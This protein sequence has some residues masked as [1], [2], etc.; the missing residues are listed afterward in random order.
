MQDD[1]E[2]VNVDEEAP[3]MENNP[4]KVDEEHEKKETENPDDDDFQCS[5]CGLCYSNKANLK[6]HM[7]RKHNN[8]KRK[9]SGKRRNSSG[10]PVKTDFQ[11]RHCGKYLSNKYNLK[12]HI[13]DNHKDEEEGINHVQIDDLNGDFQILNAKSVFECSDCDKTFENEKVL[14]I[15][16]KLKH[17]DLY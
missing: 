9:S 11:C 10:N 12:Y 7:M 3:E 15:H 14:N 4:D 16:F 13:K 2:N 6:R 8:Q 5:K 17:S 1:P